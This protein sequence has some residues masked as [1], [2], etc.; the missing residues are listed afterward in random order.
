MKRHIADTELAAKKQPVLPAP[1][2]STGKKV[3]IIGAG[4][5]GISAAYFLRLQGYRVT[6][7]EKHRLQVECSV[8]ASPTTACR[9][10]R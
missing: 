5:A 2:P 3:A 8:T 1:A 7:F 10:K 6:V 9:M 4:P